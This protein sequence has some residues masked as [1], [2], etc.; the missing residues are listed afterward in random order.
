MR[1]RPYGEGPQMRPG[2]WRS[3]HAERGV[4]SPKYAFLPPYFHSD[5]RRRPILHNPVTPS[6]PHARPS[7]K[8][9]SAT[10]RQVRPPYGREEKRN[11]GRCVFLRGWGPLVAPWRPVTFKAR[12]SVARFSALRGRPAG[13][14]LRGGASAR[15]AALD[16]LLMQPRGMPGRLRGRSS[17]VS[18]ETAVMLA[19]AAHRKA[20]DRGDQLPCSVRLG[21]YPGE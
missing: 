3:A 8:P 14:R 6:G 2:Q 18:A 17:G 10:P 16:Y 5:P 21:T 9:Q 20:A 19:T 13:G 11:Q 4:L 1:L 12:L 7:R 15:P